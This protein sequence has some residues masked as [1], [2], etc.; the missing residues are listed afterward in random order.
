M[1]L[2]MH[3]FIIFYLQR[4]IRF[5]GLGLQQGIETCC[6]NFHLPEFSTSLSY[7]PSLDLSLYLINVLMLNFVQYFFVSGTEGGS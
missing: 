6:Q 2:D 3:L 5:R 1:L 4:C 7:S